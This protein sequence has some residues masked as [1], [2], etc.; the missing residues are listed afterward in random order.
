MK[1]L[2]TPIETALKQLKAGGLVVVM[3]DEDR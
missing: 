2:D 3:D 1:N